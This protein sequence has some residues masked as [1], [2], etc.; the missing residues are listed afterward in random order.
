M[1]GGHA[2]RVVDAHIHL[3]EEMPAGCYPDLDSVGMAFCCSAGPS[4]WDR[5]RAVDRIG[6]VRFYGVHPWA[7]SEWSP[8][9]SRRLRAILEED[10][11][12]GVGEIGLDSKSLRS[13]YD[14]QK[15]AFSDQLDICGEYGRVANIHCVGAEQD[16]LEMVRGRKARF[17]MHA[18]S[19]ES[20]ARPLV[21]EGAYLSVN[22]RILAR[23]EERVARLLSSIPRD[24]L[25][26]ESD[27]PFSP[28]FEGMHAFAHRI[29]SI[30]GVP[31]EELL[32][33]VSGNAVRLLDDRDG[34]ED[35]AADRR[36]GSREAQERFR[37]SV[38]MRRSGRIRS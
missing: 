22:P 5:I 31:T 11:S 30:M 1:D 27:A 23:S 18:F 36:R 13:P 33:D 4:D 17:V 6:T 15:A 8:E 34:A 10:A 19:N 16:V 3:A 38:R 24:R 35:R 26:L 12:A 37:H 14:V 2:C 21:R 9:V 28:R 25:L 7:A 29:A 32:S 20:Y